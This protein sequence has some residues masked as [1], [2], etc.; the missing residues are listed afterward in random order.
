MPRLDDV[1]GDENGLDD[2]DDGQGDAD[3]CEE[4]ALVEAVDDGSGEDRED[5]D[6]YGAHPGDEPD[7]EVGVG[8]GVHDPRLGCGSGD[9]ADVVE[10]FG[11]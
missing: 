3:E 5:E 11:C 6:G 9:G 7:P 4:F 1:E 10:G 2:G 8:E